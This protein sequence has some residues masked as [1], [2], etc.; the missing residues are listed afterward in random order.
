MTRLFI[1]GK[2]QNLPVKQIWNADESDFPVDPSKC[3]VITKQRETVCK[4]SLGSGWEN[5][6]V[7]LLAIVNA[8]GSV[9]TPLIIYASKNLQRT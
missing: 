7:L 3:K 9:L 1:K 4:V 6:S 2:N 8:D 5:F